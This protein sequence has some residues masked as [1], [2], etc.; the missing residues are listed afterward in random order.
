MCVYIVDT[1]THITIIITGEVMNLRGRIRE[2]LEG[3]EER[4]KIMEVQYSCMKH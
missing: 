4:M 3:G 2:E 1:Y